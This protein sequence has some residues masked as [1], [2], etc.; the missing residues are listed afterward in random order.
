[1][2]R[3]RRRWLTT[4]VDNGKT[5]HAHLML[6]LAQDRMLSWKTRPS[7]TPNR[8]TAGLRQAPEASSKTSAIGHEATAEFMVTVLPK[9]LV[10]VRLVM[11]FT[12]NHSPLAS[13]AVNVIFR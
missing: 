11:V 10:K 3:W 2:L 8:N 6:S 7:T 9:V 13:L 12:K 4:R 5:I 1:M